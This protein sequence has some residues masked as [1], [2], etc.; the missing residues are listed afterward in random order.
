MP[1]QT[2]LVSLRSNFQFGDGSVRFVKYDINVYDADL[3]LIYETERVM[4]Q[5]ELGHVL[6]FRHEHTRLKV[7]IEVKSTMSGHVGAGRGRHGTPAELRVCGRS[8]RPDD[9]LRYA[10]AG[11]TG[12]ARLRRREHDDAHR[13]SGRGR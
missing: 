5:H 12:D 2:L 11:G 10:A 3:N 6:G 4:R 8:E 13:G 7:W 9:R 1:G